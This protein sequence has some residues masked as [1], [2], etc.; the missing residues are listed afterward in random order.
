MYHSFLIFRSELSVVDEAQTKIKKSSK[1]RSKAHK[2]MKSSSSSESHMK[3][4]ISRSK[5][6]DAY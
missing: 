1:Q 5:D 4:L 2:S 6:A 3:N